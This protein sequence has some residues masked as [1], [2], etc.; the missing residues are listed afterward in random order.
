MVY[1]YFGMKEVQYNRIT[2]MT[3]I[4]SYMRPRPV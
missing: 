1:M 2:N 4:L 3:L